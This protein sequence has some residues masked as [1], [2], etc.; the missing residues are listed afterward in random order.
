MELIIAC[1]IVGLAVPIKTAT[2][3]DMLVFVTHC[4]WKNRQMQRNKRITFV[5]K[6]QQ[7]SIFTIL[8]IYFSI[9]LER[10]AKTYLRYCIP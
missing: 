2:R 8:V 10:S 5:L 1:R 4:F 3:K 9:P 6:M 7:M